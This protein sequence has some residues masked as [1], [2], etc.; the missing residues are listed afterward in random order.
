MRA[1]HLPQRRFGHAARSPRMARILQFRRRF[2]PLLELRAHNGHPEPY[3]VKYW[4]V[5][6]ENWGCGGRFTATDYAKE[7]TRYA[8]LPARLR[9][10]HRIDRLRREPG[11]LQTAHLCR[12]EPRLLRGDDPRRSHRPPQH[13][14]LFRPGRRRHLLRLRIRRVVRR[15]D[16]HGTRHSTGGSVAGLLLSRPLRRT[17]HRR[18]G[19]M[20]SRR[21]GR[22][23]PRTGQYLARR[24]ICRRRP[25]PVQQLRPPCHHDQHRPDHQRAPGH[26]HHRRRRHVSHPH[27]LRLRHD[28]LPHG[29]A[30]AHARTRMSHLRRPSHGPP[31]KAQRAPTQR[32][33]LPR[34]Q[35]DPPHRREPDRRYRRRNP[36][37]PARRKGTQRAGTRPQ[38]GRSARRQ[39]HRGSQDHLPQADKARG[40]RRATSFT[41]SPRIR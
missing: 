33:R 37:R 29:R 35:E 12:L 19:P 10:R 18:M 8:V 32:Q 38:L 9:S 22:Q 11:R 26:R 23:R 3:G 36:H 16:R 1:L 20:A 6:N 21:R 31:A 14:P 13:P 7:Y 5:G 41:P 24:R 30:I 4:G 15:S 34:A 25:Q 40:G 17:R 27:L 28:A 39:H 2:R